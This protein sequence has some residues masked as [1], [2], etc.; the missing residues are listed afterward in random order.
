M[1]KSGTVGE[2]YCT[3]GGTRRLATH[4]MEE[5]VLS[6]DVYSAAQT[7]VLAHYYRAMV[8]RADIWRTRMDTTTNWAIGSTAAI[9]SFTL[10][11]AA[12]PHYVM[13][14]APLMTLCFLSLEARR[15]TFYNL[16]QQRVRL[17]EDHFIRTTIGAGGPRVDAAAGEINAAELS[18]V[19]GP[20]LG[21]TVPTMP[22]GKA[23][24]RR[25]RRIYLYVFGIQLIAWGFKLANS[26]LPAASFRELVARAE[27]GLIP[28]G[29]VTSVV[30]ALGLGA[31]AVAT[32][33]GGVDR[34]PS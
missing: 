7:T 12:V 4:L 14:I 18:A 15:L 6:D 21:R 33:W 28:G 3:R 34:D 29:A 27:I 31:V 20:H 26:P 23:A 19:L 25:L 1:G 17:I 24:A 30:F 22:L 11:D 5:D 10:S 2:V 16:F 8:G 13:S 9:V 32:S